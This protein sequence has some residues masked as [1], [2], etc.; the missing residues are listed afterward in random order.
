MSAMGWLK[1]SN[2]SED[3]EKLLLLKIARHL[4]NLLI[5]NNICL[6]SQWI[7]GEKNQVADELSRE[8]TMSDD[9]LTNKIK[10]LFPLQAPETFR[11][12]MLPPTLTLKYLNLVQEW[13]L[14]AAPPKELKKDM[15]VTGIDGSMDR[16]P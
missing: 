7:Q 9:D 8:Q 10:I 2:F 4:A 15:L 11:I 16:I 12:L 5:D 14:A 3:N 1:K 13:Q 6:F